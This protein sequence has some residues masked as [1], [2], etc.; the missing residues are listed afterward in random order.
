VRLYLLNDY[1]NNKFTRKER[2]FAFIETTRPYTLLWCGLVSL[3]GACIA[4]D[5][6]PD[7]ITALLATF[8]PIIGWIAGLIISDFFDRGLDQIQKKHRPIPSGRL[9]S[10]EILLIGGIFALIGLFFSFFLGIYNLII[11][12]IAALLVLTYAIY[13]KSHGMIGNINRGLITGVA[14]FFGVFSIN[15]SI[16]SIPFYVWLISLVFIIHDINSNLIGA[17]RDIE[18]DKI[19]GYITFPVKYGVK[20]SIII[21]ILLTFIWISLSIYIPFIYDFLND[22]YFYIIGFV[23][24]IILVLYICCFR[25]MD[26]IDRRKA[27]KAHEFFVIER[28]TLA[29]AFIF[30]ISKIFDAL[31]IY[32]IAV[33]ITII[34]QYF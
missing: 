34:L 19:G 22:F 10:Y 31:I 12:F 16:I 33:S 6:F 1:L 4:N 20:I 26:N 11:S 32:I 23:I 30:G 14:F 8:I 24:L 21:A 28:I 18:G 9:K 2:I 7:F 5:G 15:D 27:L 3:V 13:T 29:S 17:I 25:S